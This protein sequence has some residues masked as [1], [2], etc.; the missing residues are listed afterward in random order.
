[1]KV[2]A[3]MASSMKTDREIGRRGSRRERIIESSARA[4]RKENPL[5]GIVCSQASHS[6][7]ISAYKWHIN[8]RKPA[9]ATYLPTIL[10]T[11]T[12]RSRQGK[13]PTARPDTIGIMTIS[14]RRPLSNTVKNAHNLYH[15]G[16]YQLW[17][18]RE[19]LAFGGSQVVYVPTDLTDSQ[20]QYLP[21]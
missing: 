11:K 19:S 1:M 20:E 3:R 15:S 9:E 10:Y 5:H 13:I 7:R 14:D 16:I 21:D 12:L 8:S 18:R 2:T 17:G 4:R 6:I